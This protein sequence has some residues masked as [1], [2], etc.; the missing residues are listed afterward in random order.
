MSAS[1]SESYYVFLVNDVQLHDEDWFCCKQIGILF[2]D[3]MFNQ[4][5]T[6]FCYYNQQ[7]KNSDRQDLVFLGTSLSK[8][9]IHIFKIR[10][11][12]VLFLTK[13]KKL[14]CY[15]GRPRYGNL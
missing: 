3:T 6:N 12:M 8:R 5:V 11:R 2:L 13:H 15:W 9:Y 4:W 7:L 14:K 10:I 1:L